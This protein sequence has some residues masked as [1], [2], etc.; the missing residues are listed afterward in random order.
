MIDRPLLAMGH[1]EQRCVANEAKTPAPLATG[2]FSQSA[3]E[4]RTTACRR[5]PGGFLRID[6]PAFYPARFGI[7]TEIHNPKRKRGI[8][9]SLTRRVVIAAP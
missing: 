2:S 9:P 3:V 7:L 6:R 4:T 5:R 8:D 1:D